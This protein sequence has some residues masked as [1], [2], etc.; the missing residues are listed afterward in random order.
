MVADVESRGQ[1]RMHA[2]GIALGQR[3]GVISHC[4]EG[5]GAGPSQRKAAMCWQQFIAACAVCVIA[6]GL[7]AM[8]IALRHFLPCLHRCCITA[9]RRPARLQMRASRAEQ[10]RLRASQQPSRGS[11]ANIA[12]KSTVKAQ[13]NPSWHGVA[14]TSNGAAGNGKTRPWLP[15]GRSLHLNIAGRQNEGV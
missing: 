7:C 3:P 8:A 14:S 9:P 12:T 11:A 13:N 4:G 6:M 2:F 15:V 1:R 5:S 10:L